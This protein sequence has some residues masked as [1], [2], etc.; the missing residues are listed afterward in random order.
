MTRQQRAAVEGFSIF[1]RVAGSKEAPAILLLHGFPTSSHIFH[2]LIP[3]LADPYHLV[4][5]DP[6]GFGFTDAPGRD[7][8][9]Y[10]FENLTESVA[11]VT[12]TLRLNRFA[13]YV[14]DYGTPENRSLANE[15]SQGAPSLRKMGTWFCSRDFGN[16][17]SWGRHHS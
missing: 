7:R 12:E 1:Y 17:S 9:R 2:N 14:F 10:K 8:F 16:G 13:I 3:L 6:P 15:L 5:P 11:G 4:A